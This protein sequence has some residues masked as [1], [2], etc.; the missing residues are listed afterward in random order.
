[1]QLSK[2]Q[3]VKLIDKIKTAWPQAHCDVCNTNTSWTLSPELFRLVGYEARQF[4]LD[5]PTI[6]VVVANCTTCG[7]MRLFN[8]IILGIIDPKTGGWVDGF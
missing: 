6:P 1:M 3:Q 5:G 8:A 2:E 4:V 7:Q